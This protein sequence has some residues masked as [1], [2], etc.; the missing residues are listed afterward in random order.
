MSRR[1]RAVQKVIKSDPELNSVVVAKFINY[2]MRQG[3]KGLAEKIVY[4]SL[5]NLK[6]KVE[7]EDALGAFLKA[8]NNVKP[9]LEVKSRRVGG[10]NYQVPVEVKEGRQV[11]LALRWII[12]SAKKR[13]GHSMVEKLSQELSDAY[14]GR[15]DAVKKKEDTHKM[16]EA[17]RAFAHYVW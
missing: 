2:V 9:K 7:G 11:A 12:T 3:K 4:S 14:N 16:A 6:T 5:D 13:A 1:R 17:N 10:A 15:G 8:L